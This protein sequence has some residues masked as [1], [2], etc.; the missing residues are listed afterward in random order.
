MTLRFKIYKQEKFWIAEFRN[1][2][3]C[4]RLER[5]SKDKAFNMLKYKTPGNNVYEGTVSPKEG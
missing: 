2:S 1:G 5:T 4:E 3:G